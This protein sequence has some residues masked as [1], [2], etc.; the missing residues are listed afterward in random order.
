MSI[1]L[2]GSEQTA[3]QNIWKI[4]RS[5]D[6]F[7][8]E[9]TVKS[10]SLTEFLDTV[11]RLRAVGLREQPQ[12]PK[13]NILMPGGLRF[14]IV[15]LGSI[16]DYCERGDITKVP[17]TVIKKDR[18]MIKSE[19]ND[20]IDLV[21]YDIRIKVRREENLDKRDARVVEMLGKWAKT[22]KRF[23]YIRRYTFI[24]PDN[25]GLRFDLSL[26][27]E[28]SK[29][30]KGDYMGTENFKMA[31]IL[32]RPIKYEI[33]AEADRTEGTIAFESPKGI[34]NGI[35]LILQGLQR[36]FVLVRKKV[37]H[38][39]VDLVANATK[40]RP[41][42][43]PGPQPATLNKD[44]ISMDNV[45][46]S[47]N[48]RYGNYNVT[49]KADGLR[50]LMVVSE[51]GRIYLVDSGFR[52]YGTGLKLDDADVSQYK[53]TILDGEWIRH[54]K[55]GNTVSLYYAFDIYT[56]EGISV[57]KL[58]F[59]T[60]ESDEHRLA[61]MKKTVAVLS[62]A[63]QTIKDIPIMHSLII[64]VKNFYSTG[65]DAG[66]IFNDA[67][68]CMDSA[69]LSPYYTDGL[70]FTPNDQPLPVSGKTWVHQLKWKPPHDNTIDFLVVV[71]REIK[72][73]I[74]EDKIG[75]KYNEDEK[76]MLRHKTLRLFVGGKSDIIFRDPRD[77][78]LNN[79]PLPDT[80]D[81][82]EYQ[83]VE[84]RP[85][86][87]A[88]LSASICH[89]AL[90]GGAADPAGA[91]PGSQDL[92]AKI[93]TLLCTRTNDP[94]TS[95]SIVEM[96]Y[97]PEKPVGW[98]WEPIRV[99][100]D[101]TERLQNGELGRTMNADWVADGIWNSIHN[102][103]TED[104]IRTGIL[105]ED[106]VEEKPIYYLNKKAA[107]RDNFIVRKLNSFHNIYIKSELLLQK[108]LRKGDTVLDLACGRGGDIK[109]WLIN[110]AG[111]VMGVDFNLDNLITTKEGIYGRYLDMKIIN[112]GD[113]P[114]M[115]FVQ[116]DSTRNIKN[117]E[118]GVTDLDKSLLSAL[119]D[120]GP[121]GNTPP[122]VETLRGFA[123]RGFDV[124]S[125][126]F[127]I[128]YMFR[129]RHS[130]NGFLTNIADNL[131]IGG[132]FIGCCFDGD[133]VHKMLTGLPEGGIKTGR[134]KDT[135]IWSIRRNY[136][137]NVEDILPAS[138]E[139]LGKAIDVFYYSIGEEHREYLVSFEY[140]TKRM[141]EIGCELLNP[142]ELSIL[143]LNSSTNMFGESHKMTGKNYLMSNAL[144]EFSFLNRWFIFRRRS[145]G[146]VIRDLGESMTPS[147][148]QQDVVELQNIPDTPTPSGSDKKLL[149]KFFHNAVL[150]DELKI[151][152]KDWARYISP[153]THS[154][155]RDLNDP[156][157]IYPS[158]D[159]AFAS[160]LYQVGTDKPELGKLLFSVN[161]TIHQTYVKASQGM[162]D[163]NKND[164]KDDEIIS[165]RNQLKP[166][167]I[168]RTGAKYN[169]AKYLEAREDMMQ[170]YIQQRYD[171]DSEFK[172]ILNT[173]KDK[174]GFLVFYNGPRPTEMGGLVR[175]NGQI[176]GSNKLGNMYMKVLA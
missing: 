28:S 74:S 130:V 34:I 31:D 174:N 9:S 42:T 53:G 175:E 72:N 10:V 40:T 95:N 66:F 44:N 17:F 160:I 27:R 125:C 126:M 15:G 45:P 60:T 124:V 131:K 61:Y 108:T 21:D 12:Q 24:G 80:I 169:E 32:H 13:L 171:T 173:I 102:P 161:S 159:A 6:N 118:A 97:H 147:P 144:Q 78:I 91:A 114:P 11:S 87:P 170:S 166:A 165:I 110:K 26:V 58:P 19:N 23:R 51:N 33:E 148:L 79:K 29:D 176:D 129:D 70:I 96:A 135:D 150:K 59:L 36:S 121:K 98:R 157:I 63:K 18:R 168:K 38:E 43:F 119:Y 105:T 16:Q 138:D 20:Q 64:S 128:H 56:T 141:S 83:P 172:R 158:L 154:R 163:N 48:I 139:G 122:A 68:A 3:I 77:T 142:N 22:P 101:K 117:G 167:E 115:I 8:L 47:P 146:E 133:T 151:G 127:A 106:I 46:G 164:L 86:E 55:N 85:L 54:D 57:T 140:L 67:A 145:G 81:T 111:W 109:K 103:I 7:E 137:N 156:N 155:L 99:R 136:S 49:D 94:I 143:G 113:I 162:D 153:S 25:S 4:W 123:G 41:R 112:K 30:T 71:D 107:K 14:T 73:G 149:L 62:T 116:A 37:A 1:E 134:D 120:N 2:R 35:S 104:M 5:S 76:Q 50:T 92:E 152:R 69:A 75:Y 132:Y 39:I 52:V 88:D 65:G 84:F 82:E 93:E 89:I 90:D 100:W